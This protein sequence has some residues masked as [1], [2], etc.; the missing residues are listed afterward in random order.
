[1]SE[2]ELGVTPTPDDGKR[3]GADVPWDE[4]TRPR[5]P[6]SGAEVTYSEQGRLV[7]QHLIDVHDMLRH[8]LERLRAIVAE[9][10]A[11]ERTPGEARSASPSR[12]S[13]SAPPWPC[14]ATS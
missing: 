11:G 10:R 14:S 7:G 3:T 8:E 12:S 4:S 5:R 1:M 2:Y 9:V 13:P 6:E